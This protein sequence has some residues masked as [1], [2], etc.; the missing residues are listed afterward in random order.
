MEPEKRKIEVGEKAKFEAKVRNV[1]FL[2]AS[3]VEVCVEGAGGGLEPTNQCKTVGDLAPDARVT[4]TFKLKAKPSAA[5]EKFK[6]NFT[7]NGAGVESEARK[8]KVTV[9]PT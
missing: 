9:K 1:G 5:G 6:L 7:A 4:K 8:T 2:P 3:E